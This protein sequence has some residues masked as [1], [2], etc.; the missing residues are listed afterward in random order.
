MKEKRK[1]RRK[2]RE[3]GRGA[4]RKSGREIKMEGME[5]KKRDGYIPMRFKTPT[6][7]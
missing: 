5:A 4:R 7:I 2:K 6:L 3:V 1:K